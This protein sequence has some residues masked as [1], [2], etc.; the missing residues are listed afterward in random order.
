MSKTH[1]LDERR[2]KKYGNQEYEYKT[3]CGLTIRYTYNK[4]EDDQL[5]MG[6]N[7]VD[8]TRDTNKVD[9]KNCRNTINFAIDNRNRYE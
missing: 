1:Y 3:A 6:P 7:T 4:L 2:T 5:F 8:H 9:C